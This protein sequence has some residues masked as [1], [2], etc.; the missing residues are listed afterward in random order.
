MEG[1]PTIGF[2][3]EPNCRTERID[4]VHRTLWNQGLMSLLLVI[5]NDE[6]TA[7]SLVQKP[8]AR[9]EDLAHDPRLIATLSLLTNA[10][11]LREVIGS[12]ESGRFW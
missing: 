10:V 5:G 2:L 12:T 4:Q 7:Y 11:K 1:V 3:N 9:Q 8:F 6:L